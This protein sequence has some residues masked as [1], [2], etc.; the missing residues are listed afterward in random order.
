MRNKILSVILAGVLCFNGAVPTLGVGPPP[1]WEAAAIYVRDQGI[2]TGD[3]NGNLNL[4]SGLTRA[5]LAVI[6]TRLSDD[7]GDMGRNAAYY[8]TICPFT[9]VPE[10][11]MSYAGYCAEKKLMAGYGNKLFGPND[12]VT[13]AACSGIWTAQPASGPMLPPAKR[14]LSWVCSRMA[15]QLVLPSPEGMWLF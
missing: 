8:R 11:A 2:M 6:L 14:Q 9:D 5:E 15:R 1:D 7:T 3:Q 4:N 13:P 12:P 10:W